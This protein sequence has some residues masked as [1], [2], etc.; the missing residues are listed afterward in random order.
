MHVLAFHM[1][2]AVVRLTNET[3][4]AAIYAVMHIATCLHWADECGP[5]GMLVQTGNVDAS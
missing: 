2:P 3:C 5:E 4:E 1:S